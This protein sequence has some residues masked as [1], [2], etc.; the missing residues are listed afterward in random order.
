[1]DDLSKVFKNAFIDQEAYIK[2]I[3]PDLNFDENS[4]KSIKNLGQS[5]VK[6]ITEDNSFTIEKFL[7][8]YSLSEEEGIAIMCLAESLVRVPDY[9]VAFDLASDKLQNKDWSRNA[10]S[11]LLIQAASLGLN[12]SS[13]F[14][15]QSDNI[16][17]KLFN[18]AG[19]PLFVTIMKKAIGFFSKEFILGTEINKALKKEKKYKQYRFSFDLLGESSRNFTQAEAYFKRYIEAADILGD[20]YP[21][22][23]GIKIFHRPNLSVKFTSLYPRIELDKYEDI[24]EYLLPKLISLIKKLKQY[25]ISISFDAEEADRLEIYMLLMQDLIENEN[26]SDYEGI[27]FVVQ[28]Y[29]K[30]AKYIL[31]AILNLSKNTGKKIPVRLVKGAYWDSEIKY[32]QENGLKDYPVFTKKDYTDA[33]YIA[34]ARMMIENHNHIFCQFGTHN[35]LTA[36]YIIEMTKNIDFEFQ[37]LYGMGNILHQNIVGEK[38]NVRIYAPIGETN[39]LLAYLMRRMLENGANSSFIHKVHDETIDKESL[40]YDIRKKILSNINPSPIIL[41][42]D[43]YKERKN[44]KGLDRGYHQYNNHL[45]KE[46]YHI[47]DKIY[48]G[49]SI[50]KGEKICNEKKEIF[51][52]GNLEDKIGSISHANN[53]DLKNAINIAEDGFKQWHDVKLSEKQ[54]I[55]N[56]IAASL[57]EN[58]FELINLLMK[59]AGKSPDDAIAELREAVDFCKYYAVQ[60]KKV[61]QDITLPSY[62]GEKNILSHHGRG[63][64]VCI[65]PWNFPLAIFLGQIVA[66]LVT[67]N[68]VIAKP[69]EQTSLIATF[70]VNLIHK[71][72]IP[73][74]ALQLVVARGALVGQHIISSEKIA[75]VTFTGSTKTARKINMSL[76]ERKSS[77]IPFI[78]ETGGQ[79]AMI[80]DSTALLEQVCDDV[81]H[82]SFYSA[83]QRCSALRILYI[84]DDIYDEL[85]DMISDSIATLR[86][87]DTLDF[88]NDIGPVIDSAA[89]EVLVEH[90]EYM[91]K[92][93]FNI[94]ETKPQITSHN[95][96]YIEPHIIEVDNISDIPDENFGP[97]LHVAKYKSNKLDQV[98]DEINNYGYG[99]TFGIHSRIESKI[100]YIRSKIEAGNIYANRTTTGAVVGTHPFGGEKKSGTGF[101]AGGPHYLLKFLTERTTSINLTAIGGNIELLKLS[102]E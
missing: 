17:K 50:I 29:Q 11:N 40:I 65:S 13:K 28:A 55:L 95:G 101:K 98:I 99:L 26:F 66:A 84:Q 100:E 85:L 6:N 38:H 30:R 36:A 39:D 15:G 4:I 35:A 1:M 79:N 7:Q 10:E 97:I 53:E 80:V 12:I 102:G 72:G 37:K 93:N 44:S 22:D 90:I 57:E 76:A 96:H 75:G 70:A 62:T 94:L 41:P 88:A 74:E 78:A 32:A 2:T 92:K 43:I 45:K 16:L 69:A 67:G 8:E 5:F 34:C 68:S 60:A 89:K 23:S 71:A 48:E 47:S 61:M 86:I 18:K 46:I 14:V 59:E 54:K 77:I 91:K 3:I 42:E 19:A 21:T 27:G 51:R 33:N 49:Y 58:Q 20:F 82:S 9:K 73:V 83:G 31:D 81:L 25:Q 24:K 87:G 56:Q 52:P 64:F 63:I